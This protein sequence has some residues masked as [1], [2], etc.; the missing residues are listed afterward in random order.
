[1]PFTIS[2]A[3]LAIP[4][5]RAALP[6]SAVAVGAMTPDLRLFFPFAPLYERTHDLAWLPATTAVAGLVWLV[7]RLLVVP[8]ARDLSPAPLAARYPGPRPTTATR[9][10]RVA[11]TVAALALGVLTHVVWDA[12]THAGRWGVRALPVLDEHVAGAPLHSW[13]QDVSGLVGLAVIAVWF[14]LLPAQALEAEARRST[15]VLRLATGV[16]VVGAVVLGGVLGHVGGGP[17]W[18][19]AFEATTTALAGVVVVIALGCLGWHGQHKLL[20]GRRTT[21]V[22]AGATGR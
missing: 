19:I 8:A 10:A 16:G 1:M 15:R 9:P 18:R 22:A 14:A 21:E 5:R 11:L 6:A 4:L 7:W 13:F 2:H 3:V 17:I 20:A 12:F